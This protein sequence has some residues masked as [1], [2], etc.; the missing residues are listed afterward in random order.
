MSGSQA[1]GGPAAAA[2]DR[3]VAELSALPGVAGIVLGGSRARGTAAPDSD[4]DL[5]LYYLPRERP[6]FDTLLAVA[7]RLD[8]RGQPT[9][10]GTYGEWGP[11]INGGVWL[12]VGGFKT[13]ILLRD[14]DR[15]R[16]VL[17]AC[18]AGRLEVAYQP[19]HPHAFVSSIYAGEV[20]HNVVL[21]DPAGV[22]AELRRLTDPYPD[23]LAAA[24]VRQF[25]W[26]AGFALGTAGGAADR[27]DVAYVAGCA[28][29]AVACLVQVLH[30][31]NRRYLLNEKGGV[32]AVDGLPVAPPDF[33]A[34][35]GAALAA[36]AP[37]GAALRDV[38]AQLSALHEETDRLAGDAQSAG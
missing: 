4:V 37:D 27:G 31:V 13:D 6:D 18:A 28:F 21:H 35:V 20:F 3:V 17:S 10:G 36:L 22:L 1:P 7:A 16:E 33:A 14:A 8:D 12:Q 38:V 25:G 23:A 9:G 11:W 34:R 19:G 30:A 2:I 32:A 29:R 26:E 5:G 24:T 15:V